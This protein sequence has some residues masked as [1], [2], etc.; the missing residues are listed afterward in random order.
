MYAANS[1]ALF[2]IFLEISIL[3]QRYMHLANKDYF[4]RINKMIL[5]FCLFIFCFIYHVPQL[6][7]FEIQKINATNQSFDSNLPKLYK[8][9]N[10][11]SNRSFLIRNLVA[12][13][14]G[15]RLALILI[16]IY[17]LR[18]LSYLLFKKYNVINQASQT[19][20]SISE[21]N[22]SKKN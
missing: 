19:N 4:K 12:F 10:K 16:M 22:I 1:L 2:C 8:R 5:F 9:H 6:S 13:Q 20:N 17:F 14:T 3:V 18:R 15:I 7:T 21:N 11:I